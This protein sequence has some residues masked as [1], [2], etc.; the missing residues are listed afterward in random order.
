MPEVLRHRVREMQR[1]RTEVTERKRW[2]T[3]PG[4][5]GYKVSSRGGQVRSVPRKL[6]N[7]RMHGGQLLTPTPDEDGYLCVTLRD[8]SRS[9]RVRVATLVLEAFDR[10]RP[11]GMEACHSPEGQ[12]VNDLDKLRWDT[13]LRNERD[14]RKGRE[15]GDG[16]EE[17]GIVSRQLTAVSPV[18]GDLRR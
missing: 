9:R 3:V 1:H 14:K 8:G 7:G 6:A 4:W 15:R 13:H 17:I 18:S 2:R 11:E 5:P 12:Q 16:R 10:P